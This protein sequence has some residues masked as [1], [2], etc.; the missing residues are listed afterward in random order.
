MGCKQRGVLQDI[1]CAVEEG[2]GE[3]DFEFPRL[4]YLKAQPSLN[5]ALPSA[6]DSALTLTLIPKY[7]LD[8]S[9]ILK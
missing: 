5:P 4:L 8:S 2:R 6:L 1:E 9:P 3:E 7:T